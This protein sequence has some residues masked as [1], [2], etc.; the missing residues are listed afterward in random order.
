MICGHQLGAAKIKPLAPK[1]RD[2]FVCVQ[3]SL[4]R[5]A[6]QGNDDLR[7]D[8][9]ELAKEK[10]QTGGD[11]VFFRCAI[12]R[13]AAF[14]DISDIHVVTAEPHG[15]DH[16]CEQL[17]RAANERDSLHVLVVRRPL[18]REAQVSV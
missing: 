7:M 2:G 4:S 3:Q 17:P 5:Y 15:G 16:L 12:F 1:M 6:S 10:W 11:L 14:H 9:G 13:W 18:C 8:V